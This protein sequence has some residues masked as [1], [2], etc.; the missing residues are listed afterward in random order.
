MPTHILSSPFPKQ[1]AVS[2]LENEIFESVL[3]NI[4]KNYGDNNLLLSCNWLVQDDLIAVLDK[5]PKNIFLG[6]LADPLEIPNDIQNALSQFVVQ[7]FGYTSGDNFLDFWAILT[8][9]KFKNYAI[10]EIKLRSVENLYLS[11]NRKPHPHRQELVSKLLSSNMQD[12]GIITFSTKDNIAISSIVLDS[13]VEYNLDEAPND[14]WADIPND[15]FS[16]GRLDIWQNSFIN[17]VSETQFCPTNSQFV[18]EKIYK[19]IIGMRPF[20]CMSSRHLPEYLELRGFDTFEDLWPY[21]IHVSDNLPLNAQQSQT[22][23]NIIKNLQWL[24][25]QGRE[26]AMNMYYKIYDRLVANRNTFFKY[27]LDQEQNMRTLFL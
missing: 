16:L 25:N 7:Q 11:Y 27:A 6:I 18:S 14:E 9:R 5:N 21:K 10:D 24:E 17:I 15:I 12:S 19:P 22:A 1:W 13:D 4:E 26:Y 3:R 2:S 8:L 23:K 20:M